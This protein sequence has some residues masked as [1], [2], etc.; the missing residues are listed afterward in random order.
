[1]SYPIEPWM[2]EAVYER[3]RNRFGVMSADEAA[4]KFERI[5]KLS[6]HARCWSPPKVKK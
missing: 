4:A 2:K 3:M 6:K 1:M 5:R